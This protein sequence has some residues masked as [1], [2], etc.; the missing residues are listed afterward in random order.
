M[1]EGRWRSQPAEATDCSSSR[2]E[3]RTTDHERN[4]FIVFFLAV[5]SLA[6]PVAAQT[7]AA[8]NDAPEQ[9]VTR[10]LQALKDEKFGEAWDCLTAGMRQKK[11][12]EDWAKEQQWQ[13]QMSETKI[14][15]FHVFP[16][17]M[18]GDKAFVPNLLSSQDKFLNQLGVPEHELYTLVREDGGWK[19][20][21][22]QL[23]EHSE[24]GPW[25]PE[26]KP[27]P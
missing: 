9:V 21:Q 26:T 10:Y 7:P 22:Q 17:K 20:D 8:Q 19:I 5:L 2:R 15:E 12:R 6:L 4:R 3:P 27:A 23:L 16:G 1:S 18:K 24:Q 14:F 25:F 11:S 13:L